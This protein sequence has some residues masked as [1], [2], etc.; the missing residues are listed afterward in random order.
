MAAPHVTGTVALMFQVASRRLRIEETHNLLLENTRRVEHV[1]D[2][3]RFG[4][5]FLDIVA[6]VE[7]ARKLTGSSA[8]S[9]KQTTVHSKSAFPTGGPQ[10]ESV[11]QELLESDAERESFEGRADSEFEYEGSETEPHENTFHRIANDITGAFEGGKPGTLNLYDR[12]IISYGKHQ[13][14]LASGT[15][16]P[17]LKRFTEL[18]T[19]DTATK[20]SSYLDRVNRKDE[21][22]REDSEFIRLLK[23]AAKESAMV[24]AQDQEFT[25]QYWEPAKKIAAAGNIKTALGH[26]IFY[27]TKVQGGLHDV[28][29]RTEARL[30]GKVGDIVAGKQIAEQEALRAFMDERIERHLRI[31]ARQKKLSEALNRDALELEDA[32]ASDPDRAEALKTPSLGKTQ[33]SQTKRG[34]CRRA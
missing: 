29:K 27:D 33:E 7:A 34:Q 23:E 24:R 5:G 22:L 18:S 3:D 15:L 12:G 32:A 26:A 4:I 30:G 10:A 1:E 19:S 16:Y 20:L 17:I 11:E 13:A 6:V 9:F 25:R 21:T 2:S 31:S 28:L 14:T 8:A